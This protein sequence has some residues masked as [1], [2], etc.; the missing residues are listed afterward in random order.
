MKKIYS[1]L[2]CAI[3]SFSCSLGGLSLSSTVTPAA[4]VTATNSRTPRPTATIAPPT[5]TFTLT[6]TQ[7]GLKSPTP[8]QI[9]TDTPVVSTTPLALITPNTATPTLQMEGFL[10]VTVFGTEFYKSPQ[11]QPGSIK[12][13]VQVADP[14][15]SVIVDLFVRFKSK[16]EGTLGEWTRINMQTI[17][18]GTFTHDLTPQEIKDFEIFRNTWVQ[19]QFVAS[20]LSGRE[21]GR[22]EIFKESLGMVECILTPTPSVTPTPTV[23]KP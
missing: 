4:Q 8:T 13:T 10:A 3:L 15:N 6:P 11:C 1:L 20:T 2:I 17:G 23:L 12:F 14:A 22:T 7:V 19:Y 21:M 9:I 5:L 18:A 16:R